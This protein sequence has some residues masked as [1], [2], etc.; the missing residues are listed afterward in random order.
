MSQLNS[1]HNNARETAEE[2]TQGIDCR[3][4]F[5]FDFRTLIFVA[6]NEIGILEKSAENNVLG[7]QPLILSELKFS[8]IFP[9]S[10]R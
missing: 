9:I 2:S 7:H 8:F 3:F 5:D 10:L 6:G 1:L 4:T